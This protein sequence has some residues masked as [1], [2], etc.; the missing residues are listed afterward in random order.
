MGILN[1]TQ[2]SGTDYFC[3]GAN[4]F[5]IA[6]GI[7]FTWSVSPPTG[8]V[9][10]VSTSNTCTLTKTGNGFVTLTAISNDFCITSPITL[11]KVINVG[12]PKTNYKLFSIH[13]LNTFCGWDVTLSNFCNATGFVWQDLTPLLYTN[14]IGLSQPNYSVA[15][16]IDYG[17]AT[18]NYTIA[19][20]NQ[21]GTGN[22]LTKSINVAAPWR[23]GGCNIPALIGSPISKV[24]LSPNPTS[25]ILTFTKDDN[26]GFSEIRI[27]DKLGGLWKVISVPKKTKSITININYLPT[28][29]YQLQL[30]DGIKWSNVLFSKI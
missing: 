16:N 28:D 23:I 29:I 4:T 19:A 22:F 9:N 3:S 5:N 6:N 20:V 25:N 17:P 24:V 18:L 7:T 14:E 26:L 30:F 2:I 8:I 21:C 12:V 13:N 15:E 1:P 10:V 11:T 27:F